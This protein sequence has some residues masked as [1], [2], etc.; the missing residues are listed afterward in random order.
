MMRFFGTLAAIALLAGCSTNDEYIDNKE[1]EARLTLVGSIEEDATRVAVGGALHNEVSWEQGDCV[2]LVSE[3]GVNTTLSATA[4]GKSN[5]R[6]EG[7]ATAAAQS[8][9]YYAV[10]P[11]TEFEGT[12]VSFDYGVQ[13]GENFA[14]LVGA[15]EGVKPGEIDMLFKPVNALL[16]VE[17]VGAK[18]LDKAEF[19]SYGGE[20]FAT[21]MSYDFATDVTSQHT[22]AEVV[23]VNNPTTEGFFI[24]LPADL[25]MQNGYVV[26]LTDTTGASYAVAYN[27]DRFERGTTKRITM[28]WTTPSVVLGAKSSYSYYLNGESSWA[29]KCSN[30]AIYFTTGIKGESCASTYANVQNAMVTD[31]GYDVEG[32]IY[33]YSGGQVAWDKSKRSF[34]PTAAPSYSTT[35]GE[36]SG[37]RAF[38]VVDGMTYYSQNTVWLTGLPYDYDFVAKGSLDQYSADGW[39]LNGDLR[40]DDDSVTGHPALMLYYYRTWDG[41]SSGYVVSPKF[42]MHGNIDIQVMFERSLYTT[43][44]SGS[45][46]GYVGAVANTSSKSTALTFATSAYST[47]SNYKTYGAGEWSSSFAVSPSNPYVSVSCNTDKISMSAG[48]YFFA[49]NFG[50]RYAE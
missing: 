27:A 32:T 2:K 26:R 21:G 7:D 1:Q 41:A 31:V 45:K 44:G 3:A 36:K 33:S 22:L 35:W 37:I 20:P 9:N 10:Y 40:Y 6:F 4:A 13:S 24:A 17:V 49:R 11:A 18:T 47:A 43:K 46:D 25:D 23:T 15:V 34:E 42:H 30:S 38:I 8:D 50:L 28:T 29:N 48:T 16:Y 12:V 5:I 39:T 14:A 19:M